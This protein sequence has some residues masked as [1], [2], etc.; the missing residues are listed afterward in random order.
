M[1][2]A[3]VLDFHGECVPLIDDAKKGDIDTHFINAGWNFFWA[4]EM[5][6]KPLDIRNRVWFSTVP[7]D[8]LSLCFLS[9]FGK[10]LQPHFKAFSIFCIFRNFILNVFS[11]TDRDGA[12]IGVFFGATFVPDLPD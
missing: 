3:C 7:I 1:F 10:L 5:P 6:E 8:F 4:E 9:L 11:G 12:G 2:F